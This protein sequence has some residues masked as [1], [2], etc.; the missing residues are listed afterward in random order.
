V[1]KHDDVVSIFVQRPSRSLDSEGKNTFK[2]DESISPTILA[3]EYGVSSK[4]IR[5]IWNRNTWHSVTRPYWNEAELAAEG[6]KIEGVVA[7]EKRKLGR[8]KGSK[9]AVPRL[10][11]LKRRDISASVSNESIA[12]AIS[13]TSS[14][15]MEVDEQACWGEQPPAKRACYGDFQEPSQRSS[16][17]DTSCHVECAKRHAAVSAGSL[18]FLF[19]FDEAS[20]SC[21]GLDFPEFNTA[22]VASTSFTAHGPVEVV[23][24]SDVHVEEKSEWQPVESSAAETFEGVAEEDPFSKDWDL[25][26]GR[27][28]TAPAACVPVSCFDSG[29]LCQ[30]SLQISIW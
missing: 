24:V 28:N 15:G 1:L 16:Q 27:F 6:E 10:R 12:S 19:D 23:A 22:D 14:A 7:A 4:T 21:P 11:N 25:A 18:D 20:V 17:A 8:P 5:D 3:M 26:R 9:D 2:T 13:T 30:P 29:C